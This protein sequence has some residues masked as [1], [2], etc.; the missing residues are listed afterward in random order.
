MFQ[1]ECHLIR[2]RVLPS[3]YLS[4]SLPL[5]LPPSPSLPPSLS[6]SVSLSLSPSLP[7]SP[8]TSVSLSLS[9][10]LSLYLSLSQINTRHQTLWKQS[11]VVMATQQMARLPVTTLAPPAKVRVQGE[12]WTQKRGSTNNHES[13]PSPFTSL[14]SP[15]P[16][17][18]P[19]SLPSKKTINKTKFHK[20][21]RTKSVHKVNPFSA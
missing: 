13:F 19:L 6:T 21:P 17:S 5:S 18:L 12:S 16:L 3:L 2:S 4:L 14:L 7:P 11:H 1:L 9:P 20:Q 8:S 10:S 15:L